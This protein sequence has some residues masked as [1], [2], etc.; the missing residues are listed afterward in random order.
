MKRIGVLTSGGDAPGMNPALRAIVRTATVHE[1]EVLGF[2]RGYAGLCQGEP[3]PLAARD[4]GGIIQRGGTMLM[5]ERFPEFE[6][7]AVR[8]QAVER[9]RA[10]QVEGL[11][12]IGGSGTQR[13]ALALS[14][15]GVPVVG[16]PST[17]DNDLWGTDIC[18]G[19]DTCLNTIV[20]AVD[21]IRDTASSYERAFLVEVMGRDT[22]YLGLMAGIAAGAEMIVIP[23]MPLPLEEIARRLREAYARGKHYAIIMVAE[24]APQD[25]YEIAR[26]LEE[27]GI[28]YEVRVTV[29]GHVQRGGRASAFDRILAT[30]LGARAVEEL[31]AG[32]AGIMV[33]LHGREIGIVPLAAVA[34]RRKALDRQAIE[35]GIMVAI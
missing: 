11:V 23:E 3:T 1:V 12:I 4:V 22:G 2:S 28:T 26:Y 21:R 20:E 27:K 35:L 32:N 16:V 7:E 19:V 29:L 18:L 15:M 25:V 33:G 9:L 17:I 30:R 31:L 34:N 14:E 10:H 13:G 24:G 5:T 6:E 8:R